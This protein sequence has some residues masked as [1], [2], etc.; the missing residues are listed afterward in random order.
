MWD[1]YL[2]YSEAAFAERHIS[3][4]QLLLARGYHDGTYFGETPA[5]PDRPA[6][7]LVRA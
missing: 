3:D 2:A 4:V 7:A 6:G 1:L 5:L